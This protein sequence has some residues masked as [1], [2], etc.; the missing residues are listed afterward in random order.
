VNQSKGILKG[1]GDLLTRYLSG[2]K[3]APAQ[4]KVAQ[5]AANV[6]E[7]EETQIG[8]LTSQLQAAIATLP[9]EH[10]LQLQRALAAEL[11]HQR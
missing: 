6:Q 7:A 10:F 3:G 8:G 9:A 5:A 4:D 1:A 11:T 2:T